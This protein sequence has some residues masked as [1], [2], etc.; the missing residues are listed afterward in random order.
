M[1]KLF[2]NTILSY[3]E[4]DLNHFIEEY[5]C[6]IISLHY[7]TCVFEGELTHNILLHYIIIPTE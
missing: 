7:N 1:F 6:K 2:S 5:D 3:L 4:A